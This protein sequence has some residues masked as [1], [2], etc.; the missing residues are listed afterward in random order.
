MNLLP[1][2]FALEAVSGFLAGPFLSILPNRVPVPG[3]WLEMIEG[4][5][6]LRWER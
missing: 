6:Q 3:L 1:P 5:R 2:L 4:I